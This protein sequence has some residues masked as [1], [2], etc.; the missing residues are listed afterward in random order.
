MKY[1]GLK[2]DVDT[3][4]GTRVGVPHLLKLFKKHNVLATF[5]FSMGPDNTGRVIKRVFRKGFFKKACRTSALSIYGVKTLC[6]GL[7]WPGPNITRKH[8]SIMQCTKSVGH[9][10]GIHCYDHVTWQDYVH[11]FTHDK[12]QYHIEKAQKLFFNVF[13]FY[14][15][16]MGAPGWQTSFNS[17]CIYDKQLLLY[18]SDTRGR[19][20]FFPTLNG[21]K[22]STLQIPTTLPTLDELVGRKEYPMENLISHY[23]S[24]IK[25]QHLNVLTIHAELE[26]M[27][28]KNW[29]ED[30]IT[31]CN[32]EKIKFLP[33]KD[34]AIQ[35]LQNRYNIKAL[36]IIQKTIDGRSGA[37]SS[38]G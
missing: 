29:F 17:L 34:I 3:E 4:R 21:R 10:V 37:V 23:I 20:A 16:A 12:T 8:A 27:M 35:I 19:C 24:K 6:N 33:L 31:V 5:L 25:D 1:V 18:A 2:V 15:K 22:F 28:Y 32:E 13:G 26:G 7:L 14:A 11:D 30:F 9:E 38:H 36:P